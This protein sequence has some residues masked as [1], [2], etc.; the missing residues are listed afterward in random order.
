MLEYR[1][2]SSLIEHA[3][4]SCTARLDE[5]G[6]EATNGLLLRRRRDDNAGI[7]TVEG[8]IE[9]KKVSVAAR[10]REFSLF[11]GF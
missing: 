10:D 1:V 7:A 6:I 11:V 9:P 2:S 3:F 5:V 8:F 4:K